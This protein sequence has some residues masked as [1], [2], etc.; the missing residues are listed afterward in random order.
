MSENWFRATAETGIHSTG[1]IKKV[2]M[3]KC[4]LTCERV[5]SFIVL[6]NPLLILCEYL[7]SLVVLLHVVQLVV[8][9]TG[10]KQI[11]C[12]YKCTAGTMAAV[13]YFSTFHSVTRF[14]WRIV[15]TH[16]P[17]P[18][19]TWSETRLERV[20]VTLKRVRRKK[21]DASDMMNKERVAYLVLLSKTLKLQQRGSTRARTSWCSVLR[22]SCSGRGEKW[23]WSV[24]STENNELRRH[25][26]SR[27]S[28]PIKNPENFTDYNLLHVM[29]CWV[30][31]EQGRHLTSYCFITIKCVI[32]LY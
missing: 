24:H 25:K 29:C 13:I 9:H 15:K 32:Y 28:A 22:F 12:Y 4:V 10:G 16:R 21:R 5:V 6:V 18:S 8:L 30:K 27:K 11:F 23:T 19:T 17:E 26:V 31:A 20:H 2:K 7:E 1:V 3:T 14:F